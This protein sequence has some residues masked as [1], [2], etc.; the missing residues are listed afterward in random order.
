[1]DVSYSHFL[2]ITNSKIHL[3]DID[4]IAVFIVLK[5]GGHAP[6]AGCLQVGRHGVAVDLYLPVGVL[7]VV[8]GERKI[9]VHV[10]F[11]NGVVEECVNHHG[12]V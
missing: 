11:E 7:V 5:D 2:H 1:M 10:D 9:A 4:Q 3:A 8:V 12:D 6:A